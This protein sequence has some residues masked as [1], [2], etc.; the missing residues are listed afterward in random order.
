M[1]PP[2]VQPPCGLGRNVWRGRLAALPCP[3]PRGG[4]Q[5]WPRAVPRAPETALARLKARQPC[6][7]AALRRARTDRQTPSFVP[8][9]AG[10]ACGAPERSSRCAAPRGCLRLMSV[11]VACAISGLLRSVPPAVSPVRG[12]DLPDL[13]RCEPGLLGQHVILMA[14]LAACIG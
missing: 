5:I 11:R 13:G 1:S 12:Y 10:S 8:G 7:D 4:P 14:F 3:H 2:E 6:S 9:M